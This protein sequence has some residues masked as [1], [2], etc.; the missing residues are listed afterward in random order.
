MK[1]GD[2]MW[3]AL[4]ELTYRGDRLRRAIEPQEVVIEEVGSGG[5]YMAK[6]EKLGTRYISPGDSKNLYSTKEEAIE[7]WNSTIYRAMDRAESMYQKF[8]KRLIL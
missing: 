7:V 3:Y 6:F 4:A 5:G 1:E 2:V 8:K